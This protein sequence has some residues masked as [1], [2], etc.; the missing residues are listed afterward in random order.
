MPAERGSVRTRGGALF[1]A[2]L[3]AAAAFLF[4]ANTIPGDFV[5]DDVLLIERGTELRDMDPGRIFLS[6]YWGPAREDRNWR[7][8][9]LLSY[10]LGFRLGSG[11][12]PFHVINVLLYGACCVLVH[13]V[14]VRLIEDRALAS[15]GACV[16]AALPIHTEAVA[17][18]VG[19]AELLSAIAIF[20]AWLA[21][22]PGAAR[23]GAGAIALAGLITF[24]GLCAKE[25]TAVVPAVMVA[26]A[27]MLGRRIP[28]GAAAASTAAIGL[29][30]ALRA[31][32]IRSHSTP[33]TI[34]DNPLAFTDA[35]TAAMNGFRLLG[36]YM[37]K[38]VAPV[39][40]AADYSLDQIPVL[41][42]SSPR[43]WAEAS[44]VALTLVVLP[45]IL[46]RR[47]PLLALA[48]VFF[49]ITIAPTSNVLFRIGTVF[50]ERL[51][52]TPSFAW[53]LALCALAGSAALSRR[54]AAVLVA[55]ALLTLVYGARSFARNRD[56]ADSAAM[57]IRMAADSPR[58]TR[59]QLKA[60]EGY[61]VLFRTAD[62]AEKKGLLEKAIEHIQAS[63]AIH[64]EHGWAIAK[65]GEVLFLQG[66]YDEGVE[67]LGEALAVMARQDPPQFEPIILNLRG[68]CFLRLGKYPEAH[69]DFTD[70][71]ERVRNRGAKPDGPSVN[72]QA[73][74]LAAQGRLAEALSVF[75]RAV[76]LGPE[77]P[78][79]RSNRG[80]C[81]YKL[82][83]RAGAIAD[84]EQ[85]L[86]ICRKKSYF[87]TPGEDCVWSFL[88]KLA[89]VEEEEASLRRKAGDEPGAS[90]LAASAA[91]RKA[92][93][94]GL[95]T[96]TSSRSGS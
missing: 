1:L 41:P 22:G 54:R 56:W 30:F 90:R 44:A 73:L 93:A 62:P 11:P 39:H 34:V 45:A 58:S 29:Y 7:P 59:S 88:L 75:D 46:L 81:R 82:G 2:L 37:A 24:L 53:P 96:K 94:A 42:L 85:G 70:Y 66:R 49:A 71:I 15:A 32:V 51:A 31:W 64:P 55:L 18:I 6:N 72:F 17:N 14:F 68:Q 84:Y 23:E 47:K 76:D 89:Q 26:A 10:A 74:A 86:E 33:V 12:A 16:F 27:W 13:L 43:L 28:W 77:V 52:F 92:E 3:P 35:A 20:G 65:H 36:H 48:P 87:Y 61:V 60:A 9:T 40:L 8:L 5:F 63:L 4:H 19:R 67:R 25:N 69:R 78:E 50:G 38:I 95:A 21:A 57:D 80:F 79:I 83:D 91:R